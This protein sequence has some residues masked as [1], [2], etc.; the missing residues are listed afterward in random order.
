MAEL[1][2][3]RL[4][5]RRFT[6]ADIPAYAAIRGQPE[7]ARFLPRR[8]GVSPEQVAADTI[9]VFEQC[10]QT[11]GYGPWAV[12]ETASG[13]LVGHHGLRFLPEFAETEILYAFDRAVWGRGLAIEGAVAARDY[14]FAVLGLDRIIAIALPDN[15]ASPKVMTGAGLSYRRM[16][17]FRDMDVVY[18]ALDRGGWERLRAA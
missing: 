3:A 18:H 5:L 14:A 15:H 10:W 2:T 16:A 6:P 11:H 12:I 9:A 8:A 1:T 4:L 7:V 13:R 17:R